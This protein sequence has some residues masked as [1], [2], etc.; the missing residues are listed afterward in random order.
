MNE[1]T[2]VRHVDVRPRAG[3]HEVGTSMSQLRPIEWDDNRGPLA[4]DEFHKTGDPYSLEW[5]EVRPHVALMLERLTF[6]KKHYNVQ[7]PSP[8]KMVEDSLALG[9]H[10][11]AQWAKKWKQG[12]FDWARVERVDVDLE[13]RDTMEFPS[14]DRVYAPYFFIFWK[15]ECDD[16]KYMF[17][18]KPDAD[19]ELLKELEDEVA[20]LSLKY[21]P[22][23]DFSVPDEVVWRPS[24]S[25]AFDGESVTEPEWVMEFDHPESDVMTDRLEFCRGFA[26]KRPS[27][28]RD[29]GT[30]TPASLRLHREIMFPLQ[31]ACRNIKGCVYGRDQSYIRKTVEELGSSNRWFYMRDY[32]KS[33][34]TVPHHVIRAVFLGFY[35]RK[36]ELG[37]KAAKA[38]ERQV[39]H[40]KI[41]EEM[42]AKHPDTGSPLGMFV[43]GFTLLQYAM[44]NLTMS[45]LHGKIDFNATND[46][47]VACSMNEE[48]IREYT[49][50]DVILQQDLGMDMKVSKSGISELRFFYCEEYWDGDYIM[51]KDSLC[52]LA[53]IGCKYAINIVHAKE[54]ANSILMSFAPWSPMVKVA[55]HVVISAYE[56]E[57]D[58]REKTW[59]YLFGGWWPCYRD[60][61]DT[62]I[63]WREGDFYADAAYWACREH[64]RKRT[65]LRVDPP[66]AYGRKKHILLLEEPPSLQDWIS[67]VPLFGT[68]STLQDYYSL[69][70]RNPRNLKKKYVDCYI[71]RQSKFIRITRG[72]EEMPSVPLGY[73]QRHPNTVIIKGLEGVQYTKEGFLYSKP[74]LGSNLTSSALW[75]HGLRNSGYIDMGGPA[76]KFSKSEIKMHKMG[77]TRQLEYEQLPVA[78]GGV[79]LFAMNNY[80]KGLEDFY[81]RTHLYVK[82]FSPDDEQVTQT[83]YWEWMPGIPFVYILRIMTYAGKIPNTPEFNEDTASWWHN[84]CKSAFR[85]PPEDEGFHEDEFAEDPEFELRFRDILAGLFTNATLEIRAKFAAKTIDKQ[86]VLDGNYTRAIPMAGESG[87]I[88]VAEGSFIDPSAPEAKSIWDDSGSD[89]EEPDWMFG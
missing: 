64:A 41:G 60:G 23:G 20:R 67:L 59:P 58:E 85:A 26:M 49:T 63:E 75:L 4:A 61:L 6:Q 3:R 29:I 16:W 57:F 73:I 5:E 50:R 12:R 52:T 34:M 82:S 46:D 11:T 79:P 44:H 53:L 55:M 22:S 35:R 17:M 18:G 8:K 47:M 9:P 45:G 48:S 72:S 7:G 87:V 43:E 1:T 33:G 76:I 83:K 70:T 66:L 56:V 78:K 38:F 71:Q 65:K 81:A 32:T 36:P 21:L 51:E 19:V 27:E 62:S 15:E 88:K 31:M 69:I 13:D 39:L 77:L 54:L 2:P 80:V 86:L 24:S 25:N 42:V 14:Y 10:F 84:A 28:T 30:L 89:F 37:E 40:I 74:I 68:K